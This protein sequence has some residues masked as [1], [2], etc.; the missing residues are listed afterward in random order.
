MILRASDS[1]SII[2]YFVYKVFSDLPDLE[3]NKKTRAPK[4]KKK[5]RIY[6][7]V[8]AT[9]DIEATNLPEIQQSFMYIWQ[10]D[11]FTTSHH[12]ILGRTWDQ[13]KAL[14]NSMRKRLDENRWIQIFIHNASYEFCFLAGI[15]D[16]E[17]D[18]VFC[19]NT[20]KVGKF[21]MYDHFEFRC[22]YV[23]TNLKLSTFCKDMMTKHRKLDGEKFDYSR[24]RTPGQDLRRYEINYCIEDVRSL[25]E[26]I[27]EKMDRFG[28]D[29]Y[30]IP[31]T[32]TGYIRRETKKLFNDLNWNYRNE[33]Q[34]WEYDMG[35]KVPAI[36]L[37][38]ALEFA[39]RGGDVHGNRFYT[40]AIVEHVLQVD[41]SSSYPEVM[42]NHEFPKNRMKHLGSLEPW[43]ITKMVKHNHMALLMV[44]NLENVKLKD[45]FEPDP[46]IAFAKTKG[47]S[48]H[49]SWDNG[50]IVEVRGWIQIAVTDIDLRI[51]LDQYT[52]SGFYCEDAWGTVYGKLPE[53]LRRLIIDKYRAKTQYKGVVGYEA[54][55]LAAKEMLN[56]IYGMCCENP[57]RITIKY[58]RK[59][60]EP[61]FEDVPYDLSKMSEA[62]YEKSKR[63][64]KMK[65]LSERNKKRF[66]PYTWA[67]WV[68]AWARYELHR[69][70]KIINN[71]SSPDCAG[72]GSVL[73]YGD[74]D[75]LKY[76]VDSG[77]EPD[78]SSYNEE[79][80]KLAEEN[81]SV[82]YD[83]EGNPHYLGVWEDDGTADRFVQWGAKKYAYEKH[84]KLTLTLSGVPKA[85][86]A[87]ELERKGGL[88]AFKL[89]MVFEDAGLDM[90]YNDHTDTWITI[91]SERIHITPN[92][93]LYTSTYRMSISDNYE[94]ACEI[95]SEL[96]KE[97]KLDDILGL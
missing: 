26:C 17:P 90:K 52:F 30:S 19:M 39:F 16:F 65:L 45:I 70:M 38:E 79:K 49:V 8:I 28:D 29:Q 11:L 63:E 44:I 72:D 47:E 62:E 84:G 36:D 5:N 86:G 7:D 89:D 14:L 74:T 83:P 67:V 37:F 6:K 48:T 15:H 55:Y 73:L 64:F 27:R 71:A 53:P 76:F 20:R 93:Y 42:V 68:T 82:A 69:G 25:A 87:R 78:F 61:Y 22:S 12:I 96:L 41:R 85:K 3:R 51:I 97:H 35:E 46:Y 24:I 75:S 66:L 94:Q 9:F 95:A 59:R 21:D 92:V 31:L 32:A 2:D 58:D 43:E 18:D 34:L 81:D 60:E 77:E 57:C 10:F 88:E 13:F 80:M 54:I 23:L 40:G 4:N 56:S 50:R 33:I 1:D 91:G